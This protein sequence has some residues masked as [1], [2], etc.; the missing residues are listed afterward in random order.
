M[1]SC[2]GKVIKSDVCSAKYEVFT[3]SVH[4]MF[5]TRLPHDIPIWQVDGA[6][7]KTAKSI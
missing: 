6:P 4:D 5:L 1:G 3:G 2:L 7:I